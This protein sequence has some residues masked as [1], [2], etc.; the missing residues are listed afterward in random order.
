MLYILL[1]V[2]YCVCLINLSLV[3]DGKESLINEAIF[4]HLIRQGQFLVAQEFSKESNV[5]SSRTHL[6]EKFVE[7][8]RII[9]D[10]KQYNLESAIKWC[11]SHKVS[12]ALI[13]N[14]K[15]VHYY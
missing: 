15:S 1:S 8:Y 6:T 9:E 5:D 13:G 3:V 12:L 10:V 4:Q 2:Y 14:S 11:Q 7:M